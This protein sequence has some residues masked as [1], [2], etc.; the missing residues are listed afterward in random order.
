[1]LIQLL[2]VICSGMNTRKMSEYVVGNFETRR[3]VVK[4]CDHEYQKLGELWR[5]MSNLVV[6]IALSV[7]L[8]LMGTQFCVHLTKFVEF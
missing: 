3:L 2:S 8:N 5:N 7:L 6:D 4:H 1:M